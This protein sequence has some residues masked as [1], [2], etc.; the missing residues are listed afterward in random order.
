M[1]CPSMRAAR[2]RFAAAGKFVHDYLILGY[3]SLPSA[4]NERNFHFNNVMF[5]ISA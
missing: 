3:T 2:L 4:K 1:Y 5:G